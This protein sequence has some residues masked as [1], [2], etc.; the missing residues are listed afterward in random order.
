[1]QQKQQE[2]EMEQAAIA[3][4]GNYGT[5]AAAGSCISAAGAGILGSRDIR[6]DAVPHQR[7][8]GADQ[9]GS[10]KRALSGAPVG[11]AGA[12]VDSQNPLTMADE[13]APHV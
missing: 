1:M 7:H 4:T 9:P 13:A 6:G 3:A 2:W 8:N 12:D 10:S 5:S 11:C